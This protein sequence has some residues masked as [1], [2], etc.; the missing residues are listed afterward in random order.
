[1]SP[2][3]GHH[4]PLARFRI[5]GIPVSIHASVLFV[6]VVLGWASGFQELPSMA[7]WAVVVFVSLMV[8]EL[9]HA[10]TARSYGSEVA[11][12]LNGLGGLTR[13]SASPKG[14]TPGRTALVSAAGSASGF[15]LAGVAWVVREIW[16]PFGGL[17]GLGVPVLLYV[18]IVWGL[19]NWLPVRPLDGGHLLL[20]FLARVA[21][22]RGEAIAR[23]IFIATAGSAV[24]VAFRYRMLF[25]GIFAVWALM[26]EFAG[27]RQDSVAIPEF[28]YDDRPE[29]DAG[30][31]AVPETLAD[32]EPG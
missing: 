28:R 8:H 22:Q 16:G 26:G 20:A 21:P 27:S 1:M 11:I 2:S 17:A 31:G 18:N 25:I 3:L 13:W 9:G 6:V 15:L 30:D 5:F 12:E 24:L 10:L 7:V 19:L 32:E 23:G 4:G 29:D 14:M